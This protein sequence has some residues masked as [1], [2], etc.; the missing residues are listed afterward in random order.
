MPRLVD[1]PPQGTTPSDHAQCRVALLERHGDEALNRGTSRL[2]HGP[3][4]DV[5]HPLACSI[6]KS[7]RVAVRTESTFFPVQTARPSDGVYQFRMRDATTLGL[8][9]A[10]R[11]EGLPVGKDQRVLTY[12]SARNGDLACTHD[13]RAGQIQGGK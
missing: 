8:L 12:D 4:F 10:R 7:V 3:H 6:Q 5:P 9:N 13:P 11:P 1:A 2:G